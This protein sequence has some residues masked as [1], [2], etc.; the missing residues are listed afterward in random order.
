MDAAVALTRE[1]AAA[2]DGADPL[3]AFRERFVIDDP[4]RIYLD[5]NSLGRLPMAARDR[6]AELTAD[7]GRRLVTGWPEWI[8]APLR[9]GDLIAQVIGARPGEVLVC[10]SVTVNLYKLAAA[11]HRSGALVTDRG[12]FPKDRYVIE[13][14][15]R[16]RG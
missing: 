2:L 15:E 11:A 16:E 4:H 10:D 8:D 5:G 13:G 9:T 12:N 7:W 14:L 3:A 1:Q 6:L